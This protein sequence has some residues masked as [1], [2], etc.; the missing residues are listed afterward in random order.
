ML[1][2]TPQ[3]KF[4]AVLGAIS[5]L[6][7]TYGFGR[8]DGARIMEAKWQEEKAA[9]NAAAA[10]ALHAKIVENAEKEAYHAQKIR[11]ITDSFN[12]RLT[13]I[14]NE[15]SSA[16]TVARSRG[17]FVNTSCPRDRDALPQTSSSPSGGDGTTRSRLSDADAEF[18]ITFAAD[19]DKVVEQLAACQAVIKQDRE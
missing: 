8:H 13:E 11:N 4:I 2:D 12:S 7:L 5:V 9:L 14:K 3:A 10:D 18:F 17:L 15:K 19:A 1:F 16:L 6:L